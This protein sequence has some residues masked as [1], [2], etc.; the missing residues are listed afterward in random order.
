MPS[1]PTHFNFYNVEEAAAAR[2][3][4]HRTETLY[5]DQHKAFLPPLSVGQPVLLQDPK[6]GLWEHDASVIAS[7]PDQ[8][9]Y[10]VRSNGRE[11]LRARRMI[12]PLPDV[13]I[14]DTSA[15]AS[16]NQGRE[17][18][19][20]LPPPPVPVA[21]ER[22]ILRSSV[23]PPSPSSSRPA[24]S[25]PS[26]SPTRPSPSTAS[27]RTP[28]S[29]GSSPLN[30]SASS[31]V[32]EDRS[33]P[34]SSLPTS[35]R[36][37]TIALSTRVA[38]QTRSYSSIGHPSEA[39]RLP[40]LSSS[41]CSSYCST[42]GGR[43]EKPPQKPNPLNSMSS[44]RSPGMGPAVGAWTRPPG[45]VDIPEVRLRA[46]LPGSPEF[47]P[48]SPCLGPSD[49]P[50]D[51]NRCQ[52]KPPSHRNNLERPWLPLGDWPPL[53]APRRTGAACRR[54]VALAPASLPTK[55]KN[56]RS[57]SSGVL[58]VVACPVRPRSTL[59]MRVPTDSLLRPPPLPRRPPLG[60]APPR[61]PQPSG[62]LWTASRRRTTRRASFDASA[63]QFRKN[64]PVGL[65]KF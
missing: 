65:S 10:W 12:R 28:G 11:F 56:P 41:P 27:V 46:T 25:S 55:T 47:N 14:S 3:L 42:V 44:P 7:R 23:R 17:R 24:T 53:P 61:C 9:S 16:G 37:I 38:T 4:T 49:I 2:D 21:R 32:A 60:A 8:L 58:P 15:N 52:P 62:L 5:H 34:R 22:P 31:W 51:I 39:G 57:P 50:Q 1:L 59:S 45:S 18:Q 35:G 48:P 63:S 26:S 40:S 29:P 33:R 30:P 13:P 19:P 6:T 36:P 54:L 20:V 64:L 43:T